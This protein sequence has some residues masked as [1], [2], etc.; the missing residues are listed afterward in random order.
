VDV[1]TAWLEANAIACEFA[2]IEHLEDCEPFTAVVE[3][4]QASFLWA[5]GVR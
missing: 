2:Q 3:C 1:D 5:G 4:I